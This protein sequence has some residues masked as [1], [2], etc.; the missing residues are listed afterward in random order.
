MHNN[1]TLFPERNVAKKLHLEITPA[2]CERMKLF[3]E[4]YNGDTERVTPKYKPTD[5]VNLA[6]YAYKNRRKG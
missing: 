6:L 4:A 1:D 5:V 3:I 2:N